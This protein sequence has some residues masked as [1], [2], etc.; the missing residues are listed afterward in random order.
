[1]LFRAEQTIARVA[2]SGHASDYTF[3]DVEPT[4]GTVVSHNFRFEPPNMAV[5]LV[6]K[7]DRPEEE[8]KPPLAKTH[9]R[10]AAC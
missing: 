9:A 7:G 8:V 1:L 4:I 10:H 2:E 6:K 5:M 3:R